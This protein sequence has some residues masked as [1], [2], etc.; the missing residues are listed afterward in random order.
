MIDTTTD[1]V[2]QVA[3]KLN[4]AQVIP[5]TPSNMTEIAPNDD[6]DKLSIKPINQSAP[7]DLPISALP[8]LPSLI[9]AKKPA[10]DSSSI[11]AAASKGPSTL[12]SILFPDVTLMTP[13]FKNNTS[14]MT[15]I[16]IQPPSS[17]T[18]SSSLPNTPLNVSVVATPVDN[19]EY[20]LP[21]Q[22]PLPIKEPSNLNTTETSTETII[23]PPVINPPQEKSK[24]NKGMLSLNASYDTI[25]QLL[26]IFYLLNK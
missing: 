4:G 7:N 22:L 19:M 2:Q 15:S 21:G 13:R 3:S 24:S 20:E 1:S 26:I 11:S 6:D 5:I 14:I 18:S 23:L 8:L 16:S 10:A 25:F 9:V 12:A 17:D